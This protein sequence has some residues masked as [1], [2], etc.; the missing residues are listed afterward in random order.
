R[1]GKDRM[2]KD[3]MRGRSFRRGALSGRMKMRSGATSFYVVAF[4][5]LILMVI[6]ASFATVI[7]SAIARS[8]NDELSQSAYDSALAGVEE[9]RLAYANYLR[10]RGTI[11]SE[12]YDP[13]TNGDPV[14]CVDVVYW[15]ENPNCDMV[16]HILGR[17]PK[18]KSGSDTNGVMIIDTSTT[19]GNG[20]TSN[21]NQAYTCVI[22]N[23]DLMD[24]KSTLT[25]D[26][27]VRV[28][29]VN[30]K[31]PEVANNLQSV[32][33]S[34]Y[35]N[36]DGENLTFNN[37][38]NSLSRVV[39]E[40][41]SLKTA[42]RPPVLEFQLV[43]TAEKFTVEQLTMA[44]SDYMTDRAT[45]FLAPI[46]NKDAAKSRSDDY[47][48]TYN[49]TKNVISAEN[50]A[51]TNDQKIKKLPFGVY[52]DSGDTYAC[53]AEIKLPG[54]IPHR[55]VNQY[56][57]QTYNERS[58][59]TLMFLVTLPYGKPDTDFQMVFLCN[60]PADGCVKQGEGE[61]VEYVA[62]LYNSQISV[63]STGRAN[64]LYRRV[65]SRFETS[66]TSFPYPYYALELLGNGGDLLEKAMTVTCEAALYDGGKGSN[67]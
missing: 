49:D 36:R 4:S 65:E 29:K 34:W 32:R 47:I 18:D 14:G 61:N 62:E 5:T 38:S 16:G 33:L 12:G 11:V 58:D 41:L 9:A 44:S 52:C 30:F 60:E 39:F 48:G 27:N 31:N 37:Y 53:E 40:P 51:E 66:A 6:A 64:D 24:Y 19:D 13:A 21:T 56:G 54:V 46:N 26:N 35:T 23:K 50:V 28:V 42:S 8:S 10:C 15:M 59:D 25:A 45:L 20:V 43:Q 67:C 63:D 7:L 3:M 17:I 22:I 1:E 57:S 55:E 2:R